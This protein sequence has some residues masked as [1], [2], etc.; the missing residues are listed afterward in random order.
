MSEPQT[1][2]HVMK[3]APA[4]TLSVL[5]GLVSIALRVEG[6]PRSLRASRTIACQLASEQALVHSPTGFAFPDHVGP[7][8][9]ENEMRR[10]DSEGRDI[11][12]S[13]NV[14]PHSLDFIAMTV[15]VYP[16]PDS[17][18]GITA[19][20]S[21]NEHFRQVKADVLRNDPGAR[22]LY[23]QTVDFNKPFLPRHARRAV[24][25]TILVGVRVS[26]KR[27]FFAPATG[28]SCIVQLTDNSVDSAARIG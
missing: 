13:Y 9:R 6:I 2:R 18:M 16:A 11:S 25:A 27:C 22:Q 23:E 5:G 4:V 21:L 17:S 7:F 12:M 15:Y 28:L 14:A 26:A 20:S 10:Y 3:Y 8:R 1:D 24:F 19:D